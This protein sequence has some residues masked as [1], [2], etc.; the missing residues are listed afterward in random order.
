MYQ[1]YTCFGKFLVMSFCGTKSTGLTSYRNLIIMIDEPYFRITGFFTAVSSVCN[2]ML[3]RD[4]FRLYKETVF[5][6]CFDFWAY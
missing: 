6:K 5:P 4:P 3:R 2:T 1:G